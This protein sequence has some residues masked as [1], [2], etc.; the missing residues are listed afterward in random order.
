MLEIRI[1]KPPNEISNNFEICGITE[2]ASE[3]SYIKYANKLGSFEFL[4]PN[5]YLKEIEI[6]KNYLV[7]I[8]KEFWG[9]IKNINKTADSTG[10]FVNI[11]GE[12]LKGLLKK[13][14]TLPPISN[15]SEMVGYDTSTGDTE[16]IIKH[17]IENNITNPADSNRKIVGFTIAENKNRGIA[18]DKYMSRFENLLDVVEKLCSNAKI[19]F[20][21]IPDLKNGTYIF[22]VFEGLNRTAG[23]SENAPITFSIENNTANAIQV[24]SS[25][26][27]Y[28]NV[29]YSTKSGSEYENEALTVTYFRNENIVSGIEREEVHLNI[30][31]EHPEAGQEYEELK[32]LTEIEMSEYEIVESFEADV[33]NSP[34]IFEKDYFLCDKVTI[35]NSEFKLKADV[36]VLGI[37]KVFSS[38]S[39]ETNLIFNNPKP[40]ILKQI[41]RDIKN[42]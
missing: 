40:S 29:F 31:A 3:E 30:S 19:G 12:C 28:K 21:I 24:T 42:R 27:N 23:Q 18:Q 6:E 14:L 9:I 39:F 1:Y 32:R 15:T 13:R 33:T 22:D 5:L 11:S 17:F 7:L 16:T 4:I 8:N 34:N 2:Y 25:I 20:D 35:Y 36:E 37:E 41:K 26:E 38:E 10:H